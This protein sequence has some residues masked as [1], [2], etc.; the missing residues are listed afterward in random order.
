[1]QWII[2]VGIPCA[3]LVIICLAL[4]IQFFGLLPSYLALLGGDAPSHPSGRKTLWL[5]S[6]IGWLLVPAVVGGFAGH[7]ISSRIEG[8][9]HVSPGSY[10]KRSLKQR[11]APPSPIPWLG[12][13][14]LGS[15]S[16]RDFVDVFVRRAHL[17]DW[18][19]AQDH[20]E[21]AV[22]DLMNT[23]Q[24]TEKDRRETTRSAVSGAQMMLRPGALLNRCAICDI[25]L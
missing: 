23:T 20:W 12:S 19:T 5:V 3:A 8:Y 4:S 9:T 17:N 25:R 15:V 6:L 14:Y 7:V 24:F 1:M 22:S 13:Y 16:D 2:E 21:I 10:K 18:R 11:I